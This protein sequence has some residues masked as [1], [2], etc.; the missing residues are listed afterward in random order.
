MA[1]I[2]QLPKY[3]RCT[4]QADQMINIKYKILRFGP[5]AILPYKQQS[6]EPGWYTQTLSNEEPLSR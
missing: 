4:D 5:I 3:L 6:F 1:L 2:G